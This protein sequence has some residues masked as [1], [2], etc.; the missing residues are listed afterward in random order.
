M[1]DM[2]RSRRCIKFAVSPRPMPRHIKAPRGFW[3]AS[4]QAVAL[5]ACLSLSQVAL[6]QV[7]E[8]IDYTYDSLGQL[9]YVSHSG[10]ANSGV[11][12]SYQ[13]D[14]AGN[15]SNVTVTVPSAAPSFSINNTSAIEGQ[16]LTFTVTKTGATSSTLTVAYATADGTATGNLDY[17]PTS[18]TLTFG[19]S[20]T[21]QT[22]T[23]NTIDD[24]AVEPSETVLV[25]L[26]S[27][28]G[29][30]TIGTGQGTGTIAD[31]DAMTTITA[32]TQLNSG[33]SWVSPDGRFKLTAQSDFNV[34]LYQGSTPLWSTGTAG[35]GTLG[36]LKF[37]GDGNLVLYDSAGTAHW[38]SNTSGHTGAILG[39]RNDGNVVILSGAGGTVLWSTNTCCH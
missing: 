22:I 3:G 20:T 35:T 1:A 8:Q 33:Q 21:T 10:S 26:S 17:Y 12:A 34:V 25:N 5:C 2:T 30:A 4:R 23:V 19:P 6:A 32:N 16:P 38:A 24:T 29:G 13:L 7:A 28:S 18:S 9:T 27:P 36:R 31:T 37:Q 14:A 15:R 11:T 39:I